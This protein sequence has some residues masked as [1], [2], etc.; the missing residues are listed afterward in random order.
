MTSSKPIDEVLGGIEGG[1]FRVAH[2]GSRGGHLLLSR[3]NV[4]QVGKNTHTNYFF[5]ESVTVP[6]DLAADSHCISLLV[7][8]LLCRV[9]EKQFFCS[10]EC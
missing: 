5:R 4:L 3:K 2:T 1:E 6:P 7:C 9:I 10:C 8:D